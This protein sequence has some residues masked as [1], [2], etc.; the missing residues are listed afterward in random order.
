MVVEVK[1]TWGL[2][3]V[4]EDRAVRVKVHFD[5]RQKEVEDQGGEEGQIWNLRL[6]YV[7]VTV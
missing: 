2:V 5:S 1:R 4:L 3:W 6:I 7:S